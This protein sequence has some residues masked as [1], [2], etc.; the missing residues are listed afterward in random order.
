MADFWIPE[1]S[2]GEIVT[3]DQLEAAPVVS[4][5]ARWTALKGARRFP[6]RPANLPRLLGPVLRNVIWVGVLDGGADYEFRVVGDA[7]VQGFNEN[8]AG[9]RLSDIIAHAPKFGMGLRML[10]EM[11]RTSGQP[12]GYR[13]WAGRDLSGA[14]FAYHENAVLPFGGEEGGPDDASVDYLLIATV[15]VAHRATPPPPPDYAD[16]SLLHGL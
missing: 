16:S 3:L 5:I 9:R 10:Y 1:E 7:V 8:F 14:Q 12:T 13:G 4:V 2:S 15:T 11:V 6:T